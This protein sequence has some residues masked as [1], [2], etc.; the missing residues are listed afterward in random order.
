MGDAYSENA[1]MSE[2]ADR[3]GHGHCPD[4]G[5]SWAGHCWGGDGNRRCPPRPPKRYNTRPLTPWTPVEING[6]VVSIG[7]ACTVT[8]RV[9]D[10][11]VTQAEARRQ[12]KREAKE[13][14]AA[15]ARV[16]KKTS[17]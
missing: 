2:E 17:E 7:G 14:R 5:G 11:G 1:A 12:A 8:V 9:W 15:Q 4:C 6:R 3:A 10:E 13:Y 16:A